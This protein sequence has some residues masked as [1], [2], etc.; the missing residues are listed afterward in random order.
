M[1]RSSV[2]MLAAAA[3]LAAMPFGQS[4]SAAILNDVANGQLIDAGTWGGATPGVGD[5]LNIDSNTVSTNTTNDTSVQDD[6]IINLSGD[7]TNNGKLFFSYDAS[8][9]AG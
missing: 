8:T 3:T 6:L 7:G 2:V 5:T 4:A 1:H 9:T